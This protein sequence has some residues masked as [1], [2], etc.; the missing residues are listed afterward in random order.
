VESK[1]RLSWHEGGVGHVE[2]A[3]LVCCADIVVVAP[4]AVGDEILGGWV[5]D[6]CGNLIIV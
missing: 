6:G 2:E 1:I 4:E 5:H 3:C